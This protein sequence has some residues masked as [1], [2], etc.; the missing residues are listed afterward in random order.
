MEVRSRGGDEEVMEA[1][2]DDEEEEEECY[3]N[4]MGGNGM[5]MEE[6]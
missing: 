3:E 4:D 6:D 2:Y 1:E 5:T